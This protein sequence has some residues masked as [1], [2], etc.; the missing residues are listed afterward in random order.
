MKL[1]LQAA[2]MVLLLASL[3]PEATYAEDCPQPGEQEVL[4]TLFLDE[5]SNKENGWT[6]QCDDEVI[7]NVPTGILLETSGFRT[8]LH[9]PFI[10]NTA[11]IPETATCT[12]TIEDTWGDGLQYPGYYTLKYG[13][14]TISV[15]DR[16]PFT[17]N[18]VCFG[19]GCTVVPD[20]IAQ[21]YDDLYFYLKL[22]ANPEETE[23]SIVCGGVTVLEG[24]GYGEDDAFVAIE[25]EAKVEPYACCTLTIKDAG[26]DG[27]KEQNEE[28]YGN[29]VYLDWA[30][31][32]VISYGSDVEF[33]T[34][35]I[36]FGLGC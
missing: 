26:N 1:S 23:Y 22:D 21:D 18:S 36:D 2:H 16:K 14:T 8:R 34:L 4:F 25:E 9:R 32:E 31:H 11:C 6:M 15:Y 27:L 33:G 24:K 3:L 30:T 17:E 5:D 19:P 29:A 35:S 7:W 10:R 13:A 28:F 12:F 20:E